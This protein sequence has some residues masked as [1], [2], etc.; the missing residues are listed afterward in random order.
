MELLSGI[1]EAF[2]FPELVSQN[3]GDIDGLIIAVHL[4]MLVLFVRWI[5]SLI[6]ICR[7][8]RIER[9]RSPWSQYHKKK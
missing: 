3:G 9:C 4:L 5:L 7:C 2:S 8:R 1:I 6:H